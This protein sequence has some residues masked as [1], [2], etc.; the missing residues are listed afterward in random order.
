MSIK[1]SINNTANDIKQDF[2]DKKKSISNAV[3]S[4]VKKTISFTKKLI[5]S[6]IVIL[7]LS[8]AAYMWWCNWTY[9]DGTRTG[10]LMKISTKGYV[11]KTIEGEANMGGISTDMQ[12]G[13]IGNIWSFSVSDKNLYNQLIQSQGD[14]LMFYYKEK[15][16]AMPWQGKTDYFVYKVE[17]K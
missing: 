16:R 11:F 3:N 1:D 4:G 17:K 13:D 9:S 12:G 5:Y 10:V 14:R 6:I 7:L 2:A 8:G 15:N